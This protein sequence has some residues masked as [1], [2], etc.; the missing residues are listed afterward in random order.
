MGAHI[1]RSVNDGHGPPIFKICG[2]VHHRIVS[3]LPVNDQPPKFF[4]LYV[5][6]TTH[7]VNNRMNSLSTV[8]GPTSSIRQDIV[9]ELLKMLD[10]YNPF[11]KKFRLTRERLNEHTNE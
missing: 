2:Q 9:Q 4:Q 3:L 6:D 11:A 10:E 5:Y 1:D 8:D 7:E